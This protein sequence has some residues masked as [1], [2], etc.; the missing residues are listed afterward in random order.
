MEITQPSSSPQFFNLQPPKGMNMVYTSKGYV[1]ICSSVN[2]TMLVLWF[3]LLAL[4]MLVVT[5]CIVND[6]LP[7]LIFV[8]P[9]MYVFYQTTFFTF[10]KAKVVIEPAGMS[11]FTLKDRLIPWAKPYKTSLLDLKGLRYV[12]KRGPYGN[13]FYFL[14][15]SFKG[16]GKTER[17]SLF[18][19]EYTIYLTHLLRYHY[20]LSH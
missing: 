19:K 10:E 16:G 8:L 5:V 15:M 17:V 20:G 18:R 4:I 12:S 2:H 1:L 7:A 13:A 6:K 3:I 14:Q 11:I 9:L